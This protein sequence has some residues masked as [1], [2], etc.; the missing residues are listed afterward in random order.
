MKNVLLCGVN[1]LGD[2]IISMPAIL[3]FMQEQ[4]D[5]HITIMAQ[6][7]VKAVWELFP[8]P[9]DFI[10]TPKTLRDMCKMASKLR[11][12]SFSAAYVLPNSV[13]SALI[14]WMAGIPVRVGAPGH[15]RSVLLSDV[16]PYPA[17]L[18]ER[19]QVYETFHLLCPNYVPKPPILPVKLQ[20]SA[21]EREKAAERLAGLPR[22]LIGLIPGAARGASK[23]WAPERYATVAKTWCEM[24]GSVVC[25]GTPAEEPLG[26]QIVESVQSDYCLNAAGHTTFA[27]W[28]AQMSQC[29]GIV[30]NDSGGMHL[31]SALQ[32][33]F[34]VAV[35]GITDPNK[36]GPLG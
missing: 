25:F 28:A 2:S 32:K 7:A 11:S 10:E 17:A 16:R 23:Q 1:W 30:A 5:V 27:A 18:D 3:H 20:I 26:V 22:P 6:K 14:P 13:R 34:V 12:H 21:L 19:H 9:I 24:G 15:G 36:T 33:P 4:P 35:Y 29:D 8:E 31:A